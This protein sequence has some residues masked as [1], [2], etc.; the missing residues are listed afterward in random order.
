MKIFSLSSRRGLLNTT[1]CLLVGGLAL[2]YVGTFLPHNLGGV[3]FAAVASEIGT[4]VLAAVFVHWL[5][6][7]RAREELM[8][9]LTQFTIGNSHVGTSGIC[10][11][12]EDTKSIDYDEILR[13]SEELVIGL[14]YDP[15]FL[16]DYEN[17]SHRE[18]GQRGQ[19]KSCDD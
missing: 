4:F 13:S 1:L 12:I 9:D 14:H 17:S 16:S 11:F 18:S 8:S 2:I 5:F 19:D 10:D 6:D 7:M 15:R 3:D